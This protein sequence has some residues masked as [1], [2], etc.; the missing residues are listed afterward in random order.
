MLLVPFV[1]RKAVDP[2]VGKDI[3]VGKTEP[4]ADLHAQATERVGRD[5]CSISDDEDEITLPRPGHLHDRALCRLRE[6]LGD[7][8]LDLAAGLE[9][10]IGKAPG[11]ESPGPLGQIVDLTTGHAGHP[12]RDDGLDPTATGEGLVEDLEAGRRSEGRGEVDQLHPEAH[13]R[14]VAAEAFDHLVVGEARERHRR[15]RPVRRGRPRDLDDHRF[16]EGHH[17]FLV[18]EAHLEVELGE[19]RLAVAAQVLVAIA[20][21]DLEVA[22]H[23]RDHQQLL[24]LLWALGQGVHTA[25][26]EAARDDEVAG[27]LRRALDEGRCLDLDEAVGVVD[28]ADRLDHAGAEHQTLG[29]RL[30]ADIEVAVLEPEDLVDRRIR[31]VDI[32]RRGLR[33]RQDLERCRAQLDVAGG[34]LV[35]LRSGQAGRDLTGDVDDE[36]AADAAGDLVDVGRVRP[37]D[38]DLGDPVPIPDVQEDELTVIPSPMDPPGQ[39]GWGTRVGGAERAAGMRS[40][41][42]GEAGGRLGHRRRMVVG[43]HDP[44]A[45]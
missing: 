27:T 1:H 35:V 13:I 26:L 19:L 3:R 7:R 16:D 23:A 31:V 18:D 40:I 22:V 41:R 45:G 36:F 32:E 24:E 42:R 10:E 39:A 4:L 8:A 5:R 44:R 37:V 14:L 28:L 12:G 9:G 11:P 20:P 25:R 30:A 38:D 43:R 34:E 21:G 33:L 17:G 15:E 6:E 29:H 2:E